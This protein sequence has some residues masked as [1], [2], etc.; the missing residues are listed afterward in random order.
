VDSA[1]FDYSGIAVRMPDK[2]TYEV[3]SKWLHKTE[4][5]ASQLSMDEL[6][7]VAELVVERSK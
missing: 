5:G 4:P 3:V 1:E 2:S 6:K 7:Q